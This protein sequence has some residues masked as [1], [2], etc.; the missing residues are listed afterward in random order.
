M[1]VNAIIYYTGSRT[2]SPIVHQFIRY[3]SDCPPVDRVEKSSGLVH[4]SELT[5]MKS[6]LYLAKTDRGNHY[7]R[8][9]CPHQTMRKNQSK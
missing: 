1:S 6:Y 3:V 7:L 4:L 8:T 2:S 5:Q 9:L